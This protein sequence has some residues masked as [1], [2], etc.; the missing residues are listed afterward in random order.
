MS[1][2]NTTYDSAGDEYYKQTTLSELDVTLQE[3]R[4][5]EEQKKLLTEATKAKKA[6]QETAPTPTPKVGK[7]TKSVVK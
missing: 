4:K 2:G 7:T 6:E 1:H 3:N 5:I